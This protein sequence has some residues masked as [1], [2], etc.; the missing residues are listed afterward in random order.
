MGNPIYYPPEEEKEEATPREYCRY[1]RLNRR[2]E[3][4]PFRRVDGPA[5]AVRGDWET[6]YERYPGSPPRRAAGQIT[7]TTHQGDTT[8]LPDGRPETDAEAGSWSLRDDRD[9]SYLPELGRLTAEA[10]SWAERYRAAT[11]R[12]VANRN[13]TGRTVLRNWAERLQEQAARAAAASAQSQAQLPDAARRNQLLDSYSRSE[14]W[15]MLRREMLRGAL[16]APQQSGQPESQAAALPSSVAT[17]RRVAREVLD[18]LDDRLEDL[19]N[20]QR[21]RRRLQLEP[22][23]LV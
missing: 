13:A 21:S 6:V 11:G 12:T 2:V 22:P 10:E 9:D 14:T 17:A 23:P 20:Q 4:N 3:R 16:A 19:E 15:L 5:G 1:G 8:V 18:Q 7:W